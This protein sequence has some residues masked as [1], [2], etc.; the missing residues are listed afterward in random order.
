MPPLNPLRRP[1]LYKVRG[2]I[3]NIQQGVW[4]TGNPGPCEP[5]EDYATGRSLSGMQFAIPMDEESRSTISQS[6]DAWSEGDGEGADPPALVR[7]ADDP[8]PLRDGAF[9]GS[10]FP[11]RVILTFCPARIP[12]SN[13]SPPCTI[14]SNTQDIHN[15][16]RSMIPKP[17]VLRF[18]SQ[19]CRGWRGSRRHQS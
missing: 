10:F 14:M 18:R 8:A 9:T 5:R 17:D 3:R 4:M 7:L 16:F 12:R 15:S 19:F 13:G 1:C 11:S 6:R 2:F